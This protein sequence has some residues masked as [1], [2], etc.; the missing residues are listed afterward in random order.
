MGTLGKLFDVFTHGVGAHKD[1]CVGVDMKAKRHLVSL[2]L[3]SRMW[4]TMI[5]IEYH[6]YLCVNRSCMGFTHG[7]WVCTC[8]CKSHVFKGSK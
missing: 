4:T 8:V 1:E 2:V 7:I 3:L 5:C 6:K